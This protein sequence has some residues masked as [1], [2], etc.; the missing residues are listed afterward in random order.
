MIG[1]MRDEETIR[2]SIEASLTGH[3]VFGTVHAINVAAVM[4]RLISVSPKTNAPPRF[5]TS[6][7]PPAS[8]WLSGWSRALT[9]SCSPPASTSSSTKSLARR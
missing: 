5:S 7:K 6:W 2:A 8:S 3:P 1:E 4:R 9:A